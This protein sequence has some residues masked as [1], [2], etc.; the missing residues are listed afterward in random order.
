MNNYRMEAEIRQ[1]NLEHE[2]SQEVHTF[3]RARALIGEMRN[4]F[5]IED[6]GCVRTIEML[7]TQRDEYA[8]LVQ[9]GNRAEAIL[10][11]RADEHGEEIQRLRHR[12]EAYVGNQSE[13]ISRL[14][15]EL[16]SA[17]NEIQQISMQGRVQISHHER[18]IAHMNEVH[19]NELLMQKANSQHHESE[20]SL[21]QSTLRDRSAIFN[22]E[23]ANLQSVIQNQRDL[24][25][26]RSGF[27]EEEI[28]SYLVRK[29]N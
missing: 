15:R 5:T 11:A 2:L 3:N 22:S 19:S 24:Q 17:N 9:L 18:E 27:T 26:Q 8:M 21:L 16:A 1:R 25:V 7:E 6:L 28:R 4:S 14:R 23:V 20:V 12:A 10:H 29:L 13:D